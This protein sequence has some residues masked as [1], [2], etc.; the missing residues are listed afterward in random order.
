MRH[1][2]TIFS[3]TFCTSTIFAQTRYVDSL[4][5]KIDNGQIAIS[6]QYV[7]YPKMTSQPGDSL[8]KLGKL[9]SP[10]LIAILTDK[11]KGIIAH[12]ILAHIWLDSLTITSGI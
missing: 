9:V 5:D 3:L 6:A 12:F 11:T 2:L 1:F 7:W 10:K 4:I 8:I